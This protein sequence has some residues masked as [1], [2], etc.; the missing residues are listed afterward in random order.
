[1]AFGHIVLACDWCSGFEQVTAA[2]CLFAQCIIV[3]DRA[4]LKTVGGHGLG[5]YCECVPLILGHCKL[6]KTLWVCP[7]VVSVR[8][9]F[10]V[11]A[12]FCV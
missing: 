6:K 3:T 9:Q 12:G 4:H 7:C 10:T 1:M 11:S 5:I 2:V 8:P